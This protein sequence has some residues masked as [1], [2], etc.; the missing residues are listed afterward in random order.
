MR[1]LHTSRGASVRR[2]ARRGRRWMVSARTALVALAVVSVSTACNDLT[3]LVQSNPGQLGPDVFAPQ[4]ADLIVNSSRGDFECAFNEYIV[5]SGVF[6]DEMADAISQTA[7]FDLDRRTITPDSPYG[8]NDCTAQQQPGVYTPLSVARASNDVAVQHLE[9]WTDA[10]VPDRS[11]LIAVASAYGGYSFVL[12]GEGMCSA[13]FDLGPEEQPQQIFTDAMV[14]FD[15]A[16]AAATRANDATTLNLAL[17]GRARTELDLGNSAAAATDAALI[18]AGFEVDIDHDATATRRQNLVFIQTILAQFGSI[19]TSIINR[20]TADNDP[21]IAVTSTGALG[22]DGHTIVWFANKDAAATSPQAL[23][24]FS[25]AQLIIAENDVNTGDLNG[26]VTILNA[27]REAANQPDYSGGLT[28][29]AVMAD[30][31][32]QRRRE[33]FLEGHRLGDIRRLGLPLSP[34]VGAPYVDGGTYADQSCFPL[35]NV[36]RINNPNL[37]RTTR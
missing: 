30:I 1:N 23:A 33:L 16:V 22:S 36:E 26:A 17:L 25:E 19:D 24:K 10:Q 32:E 11:H 20:F 12:M 29:P 7:N 27:L 8:T 13:A 2:V 15:T 18:P 35:P 3:T 37:D 34:A 5:A 14:R 21:R 31:V 6:M 4:N 28:A 9:G